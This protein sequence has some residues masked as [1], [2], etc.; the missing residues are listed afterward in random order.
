MVIGLYDSDRRCVKLR[1]RPLI[2]PCGPCTAERHG[3]FL[4]LAIARPRER[5]HATSLVAGSLGDKVRGRTEAVDPD[6]HLT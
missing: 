4:R 2:R 3:K 6:T 1:G 5:V